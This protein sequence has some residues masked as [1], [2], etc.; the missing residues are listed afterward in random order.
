MGT[1]ATKIIDLNLFSGS[2]ERLRQV[3]GG[4]YRDAAG[5]GEITFFD[6]DITTNINGVES[7]EYT[8]IDSSTN[9]I[10]PRI[11]YV[12]RLNV[13]E[14]QG[15]ESDEEWKTF[16]IGGIYDNRRTY[17]GIY[18]ERV[19]ADHY[20]T[21]SLPLL[22]REI[23]NIPSEEPSLSLTTEYYNYYPTF[24][25]EVGNLNSELQAPNFYLLDSASYLVPNNET[26]IVQSR[27]QYTNLKEYLTSSYIEAPKSVDTRMENI[28]VLD[29]EVLTQNNDTRLDTTDLLAHGGFDSDLSSLYSLMPCGNKLFIDESMTKS[30]SDYTKIIQ[31]HNFETK[32]I[33]L[34]KEVFQGESR[35]Q[36]STVNFAVN[37]DATVS[38]GI[39]TGSLETTTTVPVR[40]VDAPTMLLYSYRNPTSETQNIS[41]INSSSY[42]DQED[43]AMDTTGIYRYENTS[44]SLGVLN[45]FASTISNKFQDA[46]SREGITNLESLLNE[47]NVDKHYETVAF[48]IEKIGG[49]PTGDSNTENTV[50]NIWL[51]NRDNEGA[52]TYLDTQ[53]KYDTEYTYKIYKYDIVQGYKY[54]LSD[55]VVT[56]QIA[57]EGEGTDKVYCL[58]FYD[59]FTGQ[60]TPQLFSDE[61]LRSQYILSGTLSNS[62]DEKFETAEEKVQQIRD[63]YLAALNSFT[64]R[65]QVLQKSLFQSFFGYTIQINPIGTEKRVRPTPVVSFANGEYRV[66]EP[67]RGF[68]YD[69]LIEEIDDY[70]SNSSIVDA[71]LLIVLNVLKELLLDSIAMI[72]EL[73]EFVNNE[74]NP[75]AL[76]LSEIRTYVN[77]LAS[78]A[79]IN[80][81][82]SHLADFNVTVE[83]SLKIIEIPLEEKSMRIVDHPPNDFVVTPHHLLDQ[84][85]RLAFYC[86]YDTFSQNAV[87]YPPTLNATD[88]ANRDAYLEGNDFIAISEQTQESVSRPRFIEVYRTTEKPESYEDFSG[89]LRRTIDL[90]QTNGDIPTDHLFVE[91][92]RENLTY[93]YAFR[94]VNENGVAGQMSPVI[95]SELVNDGGYVYGRFEQHGEEDLAMVNTK[96]PLLAFK[97]LINIVPNIQHLELDTSNADLGEP[98]STQIEQINLGSS[99]LTDPLITSDSNRYFKIR[100]TSKKT[101]RKLDI[102]IGFKKEVRK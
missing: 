39:L 50:Q 97:K 10:L 96:Q 57:T 27:Y 89:N 75:L 60:T 2:S 49:G 62:R 42:T 26:G 91:R 61:N 36:T 14:A 78:I 37:T 1:K 92:V 83:P 98:S 77:S 19:Y 23:I 41:I 18:N 67:S 25:T 13:D 9:T 15:F 33:K 45:Q 21:S 40:L 73:K 102:N 20:N 64:G 86:K 22:P 65:F 28:F 56:R 101:G 100:L 38:T 54:Q 71:N 44:A 68:R 70:I 59:P 16:I 74:L 48:R 43:Y 32:F 34:L 63:S 53:V 76:Q 52:L 47:A 81:T 30:R 79:Q 12:S 24:Q 35:L 3:A 51:F 80:S 82:Y 69:S 8:E 84:S 72:D 7:A 17:G 87:T 94:A 58:E 31:D 93:Y 6:A 88:E 11:R 90:R 99:N 46:I 66:T 29:R 95:E 5:T 55:A 4:Y 85:N